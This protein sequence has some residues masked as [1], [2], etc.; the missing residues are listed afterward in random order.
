MPPLPTSFS[1]I[2]QRIS[3]AL[4]TVNSETFQRV[5]QEFTHRNNTSD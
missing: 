1:E 3:D 5:W 2:K 4:Q